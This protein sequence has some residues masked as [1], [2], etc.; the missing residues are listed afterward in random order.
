MRFQKMKAT[1][2]LIIIISLWAATNGCDIINPAEQVPTYVHIDSFSFS[3]TPNSGSTS[4]KIS[5]VWVYFDN[6][7]V[8]AFDLPAN[9]PVLGSGKGKLLVMP[10]IT[11][12]GLNDVQYPY[13]YYTTDTMTLQTGTGLTVNF[14]PKTHYITDSLLNLTIEDFENSNSFINYTGDT[15]VVRVHDSTLVFEGQYSGYI[16]LKTADYSESILNI[17]FTTKGSEAFVEINFKSSIPFEVGLQASDL[18]GSLFVQYIYGFKP[19]A[20]WTKI[21]VGLAEFI[22]TYPNDDYRLVIKAIPQDS[23]GGYVQLDNIKIISQK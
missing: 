20:E 13:P 18:S 9:I 2:C 3:A 5:S 1:A 16:F 14:T 17:P 12:S 7:I 8:G 11:Y 6:Q 4:H 10:G 15:N 19:Q 21:Y 22:T 23:S